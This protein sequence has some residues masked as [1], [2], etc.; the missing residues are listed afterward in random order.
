MSEDPKEAMTVALTLGQNRGM[1][2]R[3][4]LADL[5]PRAAAA[6][7]AISGHARVTVLRF[8]LDNPE[9]S[10]PQVVQGTGVSAGGVRSALVELEELG[11]ITGDVQAPRRGQR[12]RYT[13]NR[14]ALTDDLTAFVAW[15]LR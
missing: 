11:Y 5:P 3:L 6:R 10:R 12:I 4:E 9:S 2:T 15:M 1:P 8:L 14:H 13:A 7:E